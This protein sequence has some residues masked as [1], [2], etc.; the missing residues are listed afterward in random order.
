MSFGL[1]STGSQKVLRDGLR[2]FHAI[3]WQYGKYKMPAQHNT[4]FSSVEYESGNKTGRMCH[5]FIDSQGNICPITPTPVSNTMVPEFKS[6]LQSLNLKYS[7]CFSRAT[8]RA[9]FWSKL[10]FATAELWAV[11]F[12]FSLRRKIYWHTTLKGRQWCVTTIGVV[13]VEVYN[14]LSI[15]F[16]LA[17]N[18]WSNHLKFYVLSH[19]QFWYCY[20]PLR[21]IIEAV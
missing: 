17:M 16:I 13:I 3:C 21:L 8:G 11:D 9:E 7:A 14:R 2:H 15:H 1:W 10:T 19:A 20:H 12:P 4:G 5:R 6:K 18:H